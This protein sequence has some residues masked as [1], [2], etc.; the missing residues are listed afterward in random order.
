MAYRWEF[1]GCNEACELSGFRERCRESGEV[2]LSAM[3]S[4]EVWVRSLRW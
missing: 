2:P 4:C 3:D 1:L